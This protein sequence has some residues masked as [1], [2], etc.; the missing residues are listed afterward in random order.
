[1]ITNYPEPKELTVGEIDQIVED[2]RVAA[3][4][5]LTAGFQVVEIHA[6]HG[7]LATNSSRRSPTSATDEYGG[8]F[9]NRARFPLRVVQAV[10]EI[11]P[12]KWPV[13]VRMLRHRLEK[14]AAGICRRASSF[15]GVSKVSVWIW[16]TYR[17][18]AWYPT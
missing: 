15:A 3:R 16:W 12:E 13:F 11:W 9:E 14:K 4:R 8:S 18:A 5:A 17:A 7:Y 6:A 1:L 2:F 10:R